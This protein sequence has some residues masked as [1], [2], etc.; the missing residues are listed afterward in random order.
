MW[1]WTLFLAV[2]LWRC[3][4]ATCA[5]PSPVEEELLNTATTQER[6]DWKSS[7]EKAWQ[8]IRMKLGSETANPVYQA[9]SSKTSHRTLWS[10]WIPRKDAHLLL[11][12]LVFA[13]EVEETGP[14]SPLEVTVRESDNPLRRF[15]RGDESIVLQLHAMKPFLPTAKVPD[16]IGENLNYSRGLSLGSLSMKG[17]HLG[18]SYSGR[19]L[20]IA[21]VRLYF[22]KCPDV[23]EGRAVFGG[24]VAGESGIADGACV[25]NSVEVSPPRRECLPDGHWGPL[26]GQCDCK[27]GHE[28]ASHTCVACRAGTF[29][30]A[31]ESGG[32]GPCPPNSRT[33]GEGAEECDCMP[34]YARVPSDPVEMGCTGAPSSPH[35]VSAHRLGDSALLLLW[36]PPF[37]LGGR[38]EVWYDLQ[39]WE[40]EGDSGSQWERCGEAVRFYPGSRG[41]EDTTVNV[42]GVNPR[43]DYRLSITAANE[44]SALLGAATSSASLTIHRWKSEVILTSHPEPL[45]EEPVSPW[46]LGG[47][48]GAVLILLALVMTAVCF[49]RRK[50]KLSHDQELLSLHTAVSY[51]RQEQHDVAPAPQQT[52]SQLFEG[53]NE[54]LRSSLKEMLVDRRTLT[55]GKA[56]GTGEFGTVYEG[57]FSPQ[58]GVHIKVAVKT[59]KVGIDSQEELQ[60]F[61]MEAEIMQSFNHDNVVKLL[62]VTLEQQQDSPV[63]TPM[64]LMPFMKHGD[65]RRFLIAT[66]YGDVP[67][68]VPYQCLLRFMIDIAAGME[69]LSSQGFIH[70]DLAARNCML[71]DD[72]RVC[73]A[74]FGLSKKI[75]DSNYYRQKVTVRM[76]IK[77]MAAESLSESIYTTKSDVWSFGVTMW[78]IVSRGRT[79]YPGVHN[80]EL[81]DLLESGYRLKAPDCDVRLYEVMHSCWNRDPTRRPGFGE[82]GAKLK[83][84][85]SELPPLEAS[86]E[87]HY[88]NQGLEVA[89]LARE[90]GG[91]PEAEEGATGNLYIP[92]PVAVKSP[93]EDEEGY[94]LCIKTQ[95]VGK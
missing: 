72:L 60:S 10:N 67:M 12:D 55:L 5:Q 92:G 36:D 38:E 90:E 61:L 47:V 34:G 56:L 69:Y 57:I 7:P 3:L 4:C 95:M 74:D 27:P 33:D 22:R 50:H 19:C 21:S 79:P 6:L 40:K 24:A 94:L 71:G 23:V 64:V 68:F 37:D 88:I 80:H 26:Q 89:D 51:R 48:V 16:Q 25:E 11:M 66:R 41:L 39:C 83:A 70:R 35:N 2:C 81:M 87:A 59:M 28:E 18:F 54:R 84:L 58:E 14:Q 20:F 86:Q 63:P 44:V 15:Y 32:C 78:E 62:G 53:L 76:P 77:W 52:S 17:F 30:P 31:N 9:C 45:R 65:L 13:Q 82:L 1:T 93:M 91:D 29:R 73:V 75:Y 8:E 43:A 46:M 85:L 42:T 49:T